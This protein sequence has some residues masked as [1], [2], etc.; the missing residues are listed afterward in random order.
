MPRDVDIQPGQSFHLPAAQ[1]KNIGNLM[2]ILNKREVTDALKKIGSI[3]AE[4]WININSSVSTLKDVI[5]LGGAS[6]VVGDFKDHVKTVLLDNIDLAI[7]PLK[8]EL[9]V[10]ISEYLAPV[11]EIVNDIGNDMGGLISD[12][13]TGAFWGAMIGSIWGEYATLFGGIA[14]AA[15][16]AWWEEHFVVWWSEE[17]PKLITAILENIANWFGGD[18]W[19]TPENPLEGV[20]YLGSW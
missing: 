7:A 12:Y 8:N 2:K 9:S 15:I 1:E 14:G 19:G 10:I 4:T 16:Q 17:W 11:Y 18:R 5:D 20:D 6:V 3:D 13:K